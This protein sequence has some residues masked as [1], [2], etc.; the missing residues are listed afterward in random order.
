MF[1]FVAG[2]G[3]VRFFWVTSVVL[4]DFVIRR[5]MFVLNGESL[6]LDGIFS[7][8]NLAFVLLKGTRLAR[9]IDVV[10]G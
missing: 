4:Y 2:V 8:P 7:F 6:A 3:F 10:V 1:S 9:S 5:L